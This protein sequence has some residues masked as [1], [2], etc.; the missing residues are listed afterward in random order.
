MGNEPSRHLETGEWNGKNGSEV[1]FIME[2]TVSL[3]ALVVG[4]I[5][6]I[7][8]AKKWTIANTKEPISPVA[9]ILDLTI[10]NDAYPPLLDALSSLQSD[11]GMKGIT[12]Y[13]DMKGYMY[14]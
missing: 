11:L 4:C 14:G 5:G 7:L 9:E 1:I 10:T 8:T 2:L 13:A 12:L 3:G 6:L